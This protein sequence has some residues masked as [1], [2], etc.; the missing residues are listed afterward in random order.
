[1]IKQFTN[2]KNN[3]KIKPKTYPILPDA[4]KKEDNRRI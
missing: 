4:T 3:D 2:Y 1:M